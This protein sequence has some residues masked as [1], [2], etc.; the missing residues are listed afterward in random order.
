MNIGLHVSISKSIDLAVDRAVALGADSFQIFPGPPQ[1]WLSPKFPESKLALFRQKR[2]D[3]QIKNVYIHEIYLVNLASE[4][5]VIYDKSVKSMIHS[6]H[7]QVAL[8]ADGVIFHPGSFKGKNKLD[9][10]KRIAQ[11]VIEVYKQVPQAKIIFEN[12][13]G[14]GNKIGSKL[15][16]LGKLLEYTINQNSAICLDTCHFFASGYSFATKQDVDEVVLTIKS[17]F[18]LDKIQVLHLNGSK[19]QF[20]S[21]RDLHANLDEGELKISWLKNL[22]SHP[23]FANKPFILETPDVKKQIPEFTLTAPSKDTDFIDKIRY[24]LV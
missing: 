20:S 12:S 11:G 18:P 8:G 1:T 24:L 16:E 23:A 7:L 5:P 19:G 17:L 14:S 13:A 4:N 10:V 3:H 6:A 9:G 22:I 2:Q 15:E 21:N